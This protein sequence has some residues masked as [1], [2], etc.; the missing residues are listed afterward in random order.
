MKSLARRLNALER[1]TPEKRVIF[2]CTM[3]LKGDE[4]TEVLS[5]GKTWTRQLPETEQEFLS[6]VKTVLEVKGPYPRF[7][8]VS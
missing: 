7:A 3:G 4:I 8:I 5:G 1:L 6:R 2:V